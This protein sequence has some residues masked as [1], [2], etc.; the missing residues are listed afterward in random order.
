MGNLIGKQ[1]TLKTDGIYGS[2]KNIS[3]AQKVL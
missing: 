1:D 2:M 3:I